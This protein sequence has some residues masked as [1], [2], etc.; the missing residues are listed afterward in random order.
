MVAIQFLALLL[1][2]VV[3][4]VQE[5]HSLQV[6]LVVLGV[7]LVIT[8]LEGVVQELQTKG[9]QEVAVDFLQVIHMEQEEEVVRQRLVQMEELQL[10]EMVVM[11]LL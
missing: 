6:A 1:Q 11:D 3:V 10:Q 9:L 7:V 8:M 4:V 5:A 2:L